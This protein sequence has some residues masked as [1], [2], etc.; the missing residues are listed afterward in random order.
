MHAM[1]VSVQE[2]NRQNPPYLFLSKSIDQSNAL[3]LLV[4]C[5]SSTLLILLLFLSLFVCASLFLSVSLHVCVCMCMCLSGAYAAKGYFFQAV[6]CH[7]ASGD[8]VAASNKLEAFKVGGWCVVRGAMSHCLS[9]HMTT[10]YLSVCLIVYLSHCL[11]VCLSV[12][13]SELIF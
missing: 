6:L 12:G 4:P 1:G 7:M 11:S 10:V 9:V 8:N 13:M 3:Y 5:F 2:R